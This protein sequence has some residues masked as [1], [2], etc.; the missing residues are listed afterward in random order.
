MAAAAGGAMAAGAAVGQ[1]FG[2]PPS[3]TGG[4]PAPYGQPG[5]AMAASPGGEVRGDFSGTGGELLGQ[6]LVGYILT[7]ITFGIY[8]PWFI[9]KFANFMAERTTFGPTAKGTVRFKFEGEGGQLFVTFLVGYLL[10]MVTFGIY[11][12][13]FICKLQKFFAEN[14]TAMTDDGTM[15][16]PRFD[17]TGGDLFVTFLVGYLLTAITFGIYGAWFMCKMNKWF[18]ENTKITKNGQEVGGL[19]FVG[20]GG[21]LLVTFIVGY[22]LTLITFGIYM[23]WFQVKLIKFNA[24]NT[25]INVEGQRLGMRFTGE[26]GELFVIILVGYLLSI[27]TFGIYMFWMMAKLF[28]WQLSNT[29]VFSEGGAPAQVGMGGGA[30]QQIGGSPQ[31]QAYGQPPQQQFGAPGGQPGFGGPQQPQPGYGPPPGGGGYGGPP[32]GGGYA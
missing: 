5:A 17:G 16:Q 18:A 10:T 3:N 23:A 13:W 29:V 22:L 21:E 28:K 25:K 1:A 24:D 4:A 31:G 19:N 20:E 30:V 27:V 6:L 2:G 8:G 12:P 26:G 9:C 7:L 11:G 15:Y 32:Q 14:T